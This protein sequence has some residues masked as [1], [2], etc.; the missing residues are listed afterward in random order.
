MALTQETNTIN[1]V[2]VQLV[3]RSSA[4]GGVQ[5]VNSHNAHKSSPVD[6]VELAQ[7]I[8]KGN[9]FIRANAINRLTVIADQIKYLQDQAKKVLEE[10][11][12]DGM[13]HHVACNIVKKP[14]HVYYLYKKPTGQDFLSI[15]SPEEWGPTCSNDF[16]G[17][18]RLEHD[19]SWTPIEN[20]EKRDKEI[21][22]MEKI[23]GTHR[24]LSKEAG[25]TF[26]TL[27][28]TSEGKPDEKLALSQS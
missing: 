9:E 21:Q 12:R 10:S 15:I 23:I 14:G 18:F 1:D 3:E 7:Q 27:T 24:D 28:G 22:L 26:S 20:V 25:I 4:P 19:Q 13:L 17:A 6:L 11:H 2:A 16:I 8:Q 5:L